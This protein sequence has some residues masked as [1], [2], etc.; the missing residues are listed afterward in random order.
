MTLTSNELCPYIK[1][2]NWAIAHESAEERTP[3]KSTSLFVWMACKDY[4]VYTNTPYK[5]CIAH[6]H[7]PDICRL[8]SG[9][10]RMESCCR[11]LGVSDHI[12]A[13]HINIQSLN[14]R[15]AQQYS[16]LV[17]EITPSQ[18]CIVHIFS[19]HCTH[20]YSHDRK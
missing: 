17:P 13:H 8:L 5:T 19:A 9:Q 6:V 3:M 10:A 14:Q 1:G 12:S 16:F 7:D 18:C 4:I 20:V 15:L 11:T 2:K